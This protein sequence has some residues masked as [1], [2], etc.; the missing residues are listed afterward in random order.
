MHAIDRRL[1]IELRSVFLKLV[2][3][4]FRGLLV[5][6]LRVGDDMLH[7]DRRWTLPPIKTFHVI[8]RI[9][10]QHNLILIPWIPPSNYI[11]IGHLSTEMVDE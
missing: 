6:L 3:E 7:I 2:G 11:V 9:R 1:I 10:T 4:I 5:R 8:I